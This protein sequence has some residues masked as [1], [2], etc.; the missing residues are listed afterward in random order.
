MKTLYDVSLYAWFP[1]HTP[2]VTMKLFPQF[3]HLVGRNF[4]PSADRSCSSGMDGLDLEQIVQKKVGILLLETIDTW[5]TIF[6]GMMWLFTYGE[7]SPRKYLHK[8]IKQ[9]RSK[10]PKHHL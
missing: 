5:N 4:A 3:H 8:H 9:K 2:F 6:D 1:P 10:V 7:R